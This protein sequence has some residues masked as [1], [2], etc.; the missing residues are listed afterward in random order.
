MLKLIARQNTYS[1]L[2]ILQ[3]AKNRCLSRNVM[4]YGAIYEENFSR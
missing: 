2:Y 3:D 4:F 1:N